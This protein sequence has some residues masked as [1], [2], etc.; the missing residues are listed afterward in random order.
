MRHGVLSILASVVVAGAL[1]LTASVALATHSDLAG[2]RATCRKFGT[3]RAGSVIYAG[4][5]NLGVRCVARRDGKTYDVIGYHT[6]NKAKRGARYICRWY[7]AGVVRKG[8]T[9]VASPE[10]GYYRMGWLARRL[11]GAVACN[12]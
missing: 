10:R 6:R 4:P 3:P 5:S 1:A 7:S 11:N 8:K 9:V 12:G 2:E